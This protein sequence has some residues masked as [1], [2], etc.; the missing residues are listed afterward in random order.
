LAVDVNGDNNLDLFVGAS[1]TGFTGSGFLLGNGD[2][3]F[4]PELS[5]DVGSMPVTRDFHAS[6]TPLGVATLLNVSSPQSTLSVVSAA[7]LQPGP[8]APESLATAYGVNLASTTEATQTLPLVLGGTSVS[9]KDSKGIVRAAPLLYVSPH[10]INFLVPSG[11]STGT[12]EV[13]VMNGSVAQTTHAFIAAVAPG[14]FELN[15]N[16]LAAAYTIS[17][18]PSGQQSIQN[19]FTVQNGS[20]VPLPIDLGPNGELAYLV[21]LGTGLRNATADQITAIIAETTAQ[22]IDVGPQPGFDGLDQVKQQIP[23]NP[24]VYSMAPV[25]LTIQGAAANTV[26]ITLE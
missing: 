18:S 5:V 7:T 21:L 24:G 16:D 20:V 12:A 11:T 4:Q 3:S 15:A 9:V 10:Q 8:V 6:F 2:G 25:D 26:Y 13:T 23:R 19:V 1:A 17:V 14:L 22:V